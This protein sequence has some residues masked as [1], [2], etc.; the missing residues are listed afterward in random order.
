MP[1]KNND[2]MIKLSDGDLVLW[3]DHERT[4]LLRNVSGSNPIELNAEE[5]R[6]F[7]EVLLKLADRID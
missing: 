6:E 5:A 1:N 3:V 4:I 7:A 2:E